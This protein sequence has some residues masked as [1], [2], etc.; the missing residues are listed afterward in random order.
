MTSATD[1]DPIADR[2]AA[3]IDQ[4]RFNA[5]YERPATL[6][7][8]PD[9]LGMTV[10]D[11]G[12]GPGWYAEFLAANGATVTAVDASARMAALARARLGDRAAVHAAD[13]AQLAGI[14]GDATIDLIVSSLALH[15]VA[16]LDAL[17]VEWARVLKTG[18]LIV[19]STRHPL[20]DPERLRRSAYLVTWSRRPGAGSA[21]CGSISGRS[22]PSPSRSARPA[23]SSSSGSNRCRCRSSAR[24]TPGIT[25]TSVAPQASSCFARARTGNRGEANDR[26]CEEKAFQTV[27]VMIYFRFGR[28]R[29][30]GD[31]K[32]GPG[33]DYK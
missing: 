12:C 33:N 15:Y 26:S 4:R 31:G 8:L 2:Y 17:F 24:R 10:L 6:A 11:A 3:G 22:R 27:S 25:R 13:M 14:V 32:N 20:Y 28:D 23:S 21:P 9:V 29:Q 16:D 5:L 19:L 18:G 30:R 7:L 1:Y